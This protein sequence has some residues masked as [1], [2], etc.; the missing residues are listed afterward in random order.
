M[1]NNYDPSQSNPNAHVLS[2]SVSNPGQNNKKVRDVKW[3]AQMG[4][5]RVRVRDIY[6]LDLK[7]VDSI[8]V[9]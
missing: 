1:Q 6:H 4:G 2:S 7:H 3:P 9:M 5:V 8:H